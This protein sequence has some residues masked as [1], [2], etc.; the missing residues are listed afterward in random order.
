MFSKLKELAWWI[1]V[2]YTRFV[3]HGS[4]IPLYDFTIENPVNA[5]DVANEQMLIRA[6]ITHGD[7]DIY[8]D[9]IFV[10]EMFVAKNKIRHTKFESAH[11]TI[12]CWIPEPILRCAIDTAFVLGDGKLA[13]PYNEKFDTDNGTDE[14]LKPGIHRLVA[15]LEKDFDE[16]R[17]LR[18]IVRE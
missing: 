5:D 17:R 2:I 14:L 12:V 11:I 18:L 6:T 10:S 1:R 15:F 13:L 16:V 3:I 7:Y 9:R 8:P 4:T